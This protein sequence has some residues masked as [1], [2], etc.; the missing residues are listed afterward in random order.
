MGCTIAFEVIRELKAISGP[1][2][3]HFFACA[4]TP[5]HTRSYNTPKTVDFYTASDQDLIGVLRKRGGTPEEIFSHLELLSFL[6]PAVR[7][8]GILLQNYTYQHKDLLEVPTSYFGSTKDSLMID[9]TVQS[10]WKELISP[11]VRFDM[12][13]FPEES[14]F[15]LVST[16]TAYV[17]NFVKQKLSRFL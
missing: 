7:S 14:H 10:L 2:P 16:K 17:M 4:S 6:L 8:D 1:L 3:V 5:P 13:L 12:E 15:F 9:T 11:L